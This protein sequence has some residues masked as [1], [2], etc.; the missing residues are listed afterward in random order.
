MSLLW[1]DKEFRTEKTALQLLEWERFW[2]SLAPNRLARLLL[3][4]NVPGCVLVNKVDTFWS[5]TVSKA[6]WWR[7]TFFGTT[8][9]RCYPKRKLNRAAE[10]MRKPVDFFEKNNFKEKITH[11]QVTLQGVGVCFYIS[12][13]CFSTAKMLFIIKG[14]YGLNLML[15]CTIL[16]IQSIVKCLYSLL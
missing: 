2:R 15:L 6:A 1:G 11:I 10:K 13:M 7:T 16:H 5:Q 3:W 14:R 8:Y 12:T 9:W 4:H